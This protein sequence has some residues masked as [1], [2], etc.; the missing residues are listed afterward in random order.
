MKKSALTIFG[1]GADTKSKFCF[2]QN[3]VIKCS[4]EFGNLAFSENCAN[5][6]KAIKQY[7]CKFD[8]VAFDLHPDY[9]SSRHAKTLKSA[10]YLAVQHHYAHIAAVLMGQKIEK[11]VIGVAFDG[12]GYGNDGAVWGGEFFHVHKGKFERIA[13]FKYLNMFGGEQAII[14]PMRMGFSLLYSVYGEEAVRKKIGLVPGRQES[15]KIFTKM[16]QNKINSPLTSSVGRIFDGI[17]SLLG[18][19]QK[20]EQEAEAAIALEQ[21]ASRSSEK[22]AYEFELNASH[23]PYVFT[24]GALVSEILHDL[25]QKTCREDMAKKFHNGLANAIARMV[26]II[27]KEYAVSDV[28]LAG[29][30]F[31]NEVLLETTQKKLVEAGCN[32]LYNNGTAVG[33]ASIGLGQIYAAIY[34]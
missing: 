14:N 10:R 30:V 28:V 16:A 34:S 3:D 12:T 23:R 2:W 21:L 19:S 25:K 22:S 18:V 9:Y 7:N 11:P 6:Q 13:H 24:Y 27:K 15:Y 31:L 33:D 1:A 17:A 20:V 5:Y 29:G 4:K 26:S 8:I 32:L